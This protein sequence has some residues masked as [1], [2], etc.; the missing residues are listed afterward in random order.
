MIS[1]EDL[2]LFEFADAPEAAL[3]LLKARLVPD[4]DAATPHIA[5]SASA[6]DS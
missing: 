1:P 5:H 3:A 2:Q 6:Q 4:G